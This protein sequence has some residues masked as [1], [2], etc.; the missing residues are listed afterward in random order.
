MP[1]RATIHATLLL[2]VSFL[3]VLCGLPLG[4]QRIASD[5]RP[6]G[7]CAVRTRHRGETAYGEE[8][9]TPYGSGV[10]TLRVG[11]LSQ[12]TKAQH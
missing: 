10:G 11:C 1:V 3:P 2:R 9:I 12:V 6:W 5:D 4:N 7:M 8:S